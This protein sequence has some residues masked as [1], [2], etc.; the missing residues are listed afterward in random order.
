M[1]WLN[2]SNA[3][4]YEVQFSIDWM[5]YHDLYNMNLSRGG[6]YGYTHGSYTPPLK[7]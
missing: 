7:H 5:V 2:L 6:W 1:N 3:I 4:E